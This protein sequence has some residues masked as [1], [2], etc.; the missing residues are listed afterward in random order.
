MEKL[1][2][3]R[4]LAPS[5]GKKTELAPDKKDWLVI[6]EVPDIMHTGHVHCNGVKMYHGTWLVNSGCFQGQTD[7]MKSLGIVPSPGKPN[8]ISLKDFKLTTLNLSG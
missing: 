4:H 3:S 2:M 6:N 5:F 1:M 7:F 8:I